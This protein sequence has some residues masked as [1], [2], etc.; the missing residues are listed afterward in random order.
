M[1][2]IKFENT[3]SWLEPVSLIVLVL[4]YDNPEEKHTVLLKCD[5]SLIMQTAL[6][7]IRSIYIITQQCGVICYKYLH[8][9]KS[10]DLHYHAFR[11][12]IQGMQ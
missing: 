2:A 8:V 3:C 12:F 9:T 4:G 11:Y 7:W 1:N 6:Y 5:V 10:I